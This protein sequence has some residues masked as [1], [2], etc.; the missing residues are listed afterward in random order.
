MLCVTGQS[1]ISSDWKGPLT[2][3]WNREKI[4]IERAEAKRLDNQGQIL[5]WRT[6][7]NEDDQSKEIEWP[8]IIVLQCLK[9]APGCQGL[10][11]VHITFFHMLVVAPWICEVAMCGISPL[12][13]SSLK[14][15]FTTIATSRSLNQPFGRNQVLVCTAD[16]GI[17]KK[18]A[19]P[20]VSVMRPSIRNLR[21]IQSIK[22]PKTFYP[23]SWRKKLTAIAIQR[24]PT[25]RA[26]EAKRKLI[27]M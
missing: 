22:C 5:A 15:R 7:R 14:T 20:T 12:L 3:G 21:L 13:G 17:K 8:Q 18:E 26:Y 10:P 4:C 11:I 24:S 2:Y 16:A 23:N 27:G 25:L 6:L 1:G 9:E 19:I